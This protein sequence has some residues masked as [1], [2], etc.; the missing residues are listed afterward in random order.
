MLNSPKS[1]SGRND[2]VTVLFIEQNRVFS[3]IE[4]Y[5]FEVLETGLVFEAA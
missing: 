3:P 2:F 4:M 5:L 1:G